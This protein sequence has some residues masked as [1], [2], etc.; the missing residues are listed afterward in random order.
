MSDEQASVIHGV[1]AGTDPGNA[2]FSDFSTSVADRVLDV[3]KDSFVAGAQFSFDCDSSNS[4]SRPEISMPGPTHP[5]RSQYKPTNTSL[6][7][8]YARYS[9]CGGCGRAPTSNITAVN[10]NAERAR[11][12][13][14]RSSASSPS[15]ELTNTRRRR[16]GVRTTTSPANP[17][18]PDRP[19]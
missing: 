17:W 3:V 2:A 14:C 12:T 4:S 8:K 1:L 6:C 13:A 7:A 15:V 9:S 19:L 16:S 18:F 11:D 10:R 5:Y